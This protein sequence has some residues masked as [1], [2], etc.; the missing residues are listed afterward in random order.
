MAEARKA[1]GPTMHTRQTLP[2]WDGWYGSAA[3][4]PISGPGAATVQTATMISLLTPEYQKRMVQMN[5]HEAVTTR[6]SGW[7]RSVIPKA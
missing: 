6:L 4:V 5:Y 3:D 7:R 2:D 1:G